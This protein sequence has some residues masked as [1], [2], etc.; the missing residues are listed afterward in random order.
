MAPMTGVL[1]WGDTSS[2]EKTNRGGV[3]PYVRTAGIYGALPGDG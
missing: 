1:S 2:L 3:A